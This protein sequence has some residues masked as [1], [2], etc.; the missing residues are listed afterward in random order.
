[1]ANQHC[2]PCEAFKE[3]HAMYPDAENYS[4]L[5]SLKIA[6]IGKK[7]ENGATRNIPNSLLMTLTQILLTDNT[8]TIEIYNKKTIGSVKDILMEKLQ[9]DKQFL[10]KV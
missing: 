7:I 4:H 9:F 3:E 1:M 10:C 8:I 5:L 2:S 6:V